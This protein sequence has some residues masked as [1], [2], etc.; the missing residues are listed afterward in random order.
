MKICIISYL[1]TSPAWIFYKDIFEKIKLKVD[2]Y[3]NTISEKRLTEYQYIIIFGV[4]KNIQR[5][6]EIN[7]RAKFGVLEPRAAQKR[8]FSEYDFIIA[9]SLEAKKYFEK[10]YLPIFIMPTM[11]I[12]EN[13]GLQNEVANSN[14]KLILGY[15]GNKIHL[16]S[17]EKNLF[18]IIRT[19]REDM[20]IE[21]W[22]IYNMIKLGTWNVPRDVR[23]NI[24][25]FQYDPET[26]YSQLVQMDI[27][28]VPQSI[29]VTKNKLL[30]YLI[31][32]VN[33]RYNERHDNFI[34]R[35]KETTNSGRAYVFG[36]AKVPV[37]CDLT[38]SS[39]ALIG[40]DENGLLAHDY[41]SWLYHIRL[42]AENKNLRNL[43]ANRL[44]TKTMSVIT[45]MLEGDDFKHFLNGLR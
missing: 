44:H 32:S 9:N 8:N 7:P 12:F 38:P 1:N 41:N 30:R 3:E 42:M 17:I 37:I 15:H 14:K 45:Q 40:E 5:L 34:M 24:R 27:G 23:P 25:T 22:A 16:H 36:Q 11:P 13:E 35:F 2:I 4:S 28:L 39:T 18:E 19:L 20:E 43:Y 31:G 33:H 29:P 6:K 21:F 26:I 10:Y